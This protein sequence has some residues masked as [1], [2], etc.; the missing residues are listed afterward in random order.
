MKLALGGGAAPP[1]KDAETTESK[2]AKPSLTA[3]SRPSSLAER[4]AARRAAAAAPPAKDVETESTP[5]QPSSTVASR[6][7]ALAERAAARR[8]AAAAPSANVA[9][10]PA[11]VAETTESKPTT[12]SSTVASRPSALAESASAQRA[13]AAAPSANVAETTESK[14][15]TSSST[16]SS[17]SSETEALKSEV[18]TLR[19]K[20]SMIE[21]VFSTTIE[22]RLIM[23]EANTSKTRV[24]DEGADAKRGAELDALVAQMLPMEGRLSML[25]ETIAERAFSVHNVSATV[26]LSPVPPSPTMNAIEKRLEAL[27]KRA[28]SAMTSP[29]TERSSGEKE[30]SNSQLTLEAVRSAA[31]TAVKTEFDERRASLEQLL[32]SQFEKLTLVQQ[33]AEKHVAKLQEAAAMSAKPAIP[34]ELFDLLHTFSA[35]IDA[36]EGSHGAATEETASLKR[37]VADA[38]ALASRVSSELAAISTNSDAPVTAASVAQWLSE[39]Q[40]LR[41]EVGSML[42]QQDAMRAVVEGERDARRHSIRELNDQISAPLG[43]LDAFSAEMGALR[44]DVAR[45][46]SFPASSAVSEAANSAAARAA[47]AVDERAAEAAEIAASRAV[48]AVRDDMSS[49]KRSVAE[50]VALASRVSGEMAAVSAVAGT[51]TFNQGTT[52][53]TD[54]PV[55][56]SSVAQ[57]LRESQLLRDEVGGMLTQQNALISA[58]DGEREARRQAI[59]E[60]SERISA[61]A[62]GSSPAAQADAQADKRIRQL[63]ERS[64]ASSGEAGAAVAAATAAQQRCTN[65]EW[66]VDRL[67]DAHGL[68]ATRELVSLS[69]AKVSAL[70]GEVARLHR[71]IARVRGGGQY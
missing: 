16:S 29:T 42:A 26:P 53:G 17:S 70:A 44:S 47:A 11:N 18:A 35:K 19:E 39:T 51:S 68:K 46:A 3:A 6:P 64:Y 62:S 45:L 15:A 9:A 33:V 69:E 71:E 59:R 14:P 10:P 41:D 32:E 4:A 67:Q 28:A 48:G 8:A 37:S 56:A 60:L 7:S 66:R 31:A 54:G 24:Q 43:R 12:S 52:F 20:I 58:M 30:E 22:R 1:A 65:L 2:P 23:L 13:A 40:Q 61:L 63:E 21:T 49:L 5:A 36:L 34:A 25:E 57:W 38:V 50:A 27:E 55:T